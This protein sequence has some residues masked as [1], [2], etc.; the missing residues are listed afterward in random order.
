MGTRG[1][2]FLIEHFIHFV[3]LFLQNLLGR[4]YITLEL[5]MILQWEW[6]ILFTFLYFLPYF[7]PS[8]VFT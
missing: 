2:S 3:Y 7:D 6:V 1:L 5:L 8:L 4:L